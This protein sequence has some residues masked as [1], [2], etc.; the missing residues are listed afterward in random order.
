MIY[1]DERESEVV[2]DEVETFSKR[3]KKYSVKLLYWQIC[4]KICL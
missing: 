4:Q 1:E 3:L 2:G